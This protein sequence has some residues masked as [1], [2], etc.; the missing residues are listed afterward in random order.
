MFVF[1]YIQVN[2]LDMFELPTEV[3][4]Y[5]FVLQTYMTEGAVSLVDI[6]GL[7]I[8]YTWQVKYTLAVHLLSDPLNRGQR[9]GGAGGGWGVY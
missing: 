1:L 2:V 6:T 4:P 8:G 9:E 5:F 7:L 3:L